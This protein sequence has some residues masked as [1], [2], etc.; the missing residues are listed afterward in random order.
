MNDLQNIGNVFDQQ[1]QNPPNQ[2]PAGWNYQYENA[3]GKQRADFKKLA[4]SFVRGKMSWDMYMDLFV[5]EQTDYKLLSND[6][7]KKI[8]YSK[9]VGEA[10]QMAS[11]DY[12]PMKPDFKD[13][14]F[15]HYA[16][17]LGNLFEPE[18]E[19][20]QA[21]LTFEQRIQLQ[22]EHPADYFQN[23]LGLFHRAY[24][25]THR[26]YQFFYNKVIVG[27]INLEMRNHL[28]LNLP[29]PID[30]YKLFRDNI[31]EIATIVRR[32][33]LDGEI[34]EAE[35]MG[36]EA[37]ATINAA[38]QN[39]GGA[40]N[41]LSDSKI[42]TCYHCRDPKHFIS[43]C[44]RKAAGLP[45]TV[46]V[47]D[48]VNNTSSRPVKYNGPR[49]T[50]EMFPKNKFKTKSLHKQG[51]RAGKIMFVYENEEGILNC[52]PVEDN[53]EEEEDNNNE[54]TMKEGV[55]MIADQD[56]HSES[57]FSLVLF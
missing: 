48:K 57:D 39:P 35:A 22:G 26:D 42:R 10:F 9:L 55:E 1:G 47:K 37:Y 19:S 53:Q 23:K 20:G 15:I 11:P 51:G 16:K 56:D 25:K 34:S 2:L 41:A 14:S 5:T 46:V 24:K 38:Q 32:K 49:Y 45:P 21:K 4:P 6:D 7:C 30:N 50:S 13:L 28:R 43:Q 29:K 36:A 54:D 27:L 52:E 3:V 12:H 40:V 17:K 33:H 31:M 18:S 8:L 44:P